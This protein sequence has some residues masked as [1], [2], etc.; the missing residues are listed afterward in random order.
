MAFAEPIDVASLEETPP[1]HDL[2]NR[3]KNQF[4]QTRGFCG[5]ERVHQNCAGN[6]SGA[7]DIGNTDGKRILSLVR[8]PL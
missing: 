3:M 4:C 2:V 5:S 1:V 8:I 6:A 7:R